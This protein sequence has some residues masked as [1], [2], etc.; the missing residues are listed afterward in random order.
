[1]SLPLSLC[2]Y[3]YPA[4]LKKFKP[5]HNFAE[6]SRNK[7]CFNNFKVSSITF[8]LI[9]LPFLP[10]ALHKF[11]TRKVLLCTWLKFILPLLCTQNHRVA[12]EIYNIGLLMVNIEF[13][14]RGWETGREMSFSFIELFSWCTFLLISHFVFRLKIY[15][16]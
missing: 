14:W 6:N 9:L 10:F 15:N 1:M 11:G 8:A 13:I 16:K 7:P 5:L 12:E 2:T 4:I 3:I